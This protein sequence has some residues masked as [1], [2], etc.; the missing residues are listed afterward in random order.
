MSEYAAGREPRAPRPDARRDSATGCHARAR[1]GRDGTNALAC[2]GAA[3][4]RRIL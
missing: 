2:H 4:A 1:S 3:C